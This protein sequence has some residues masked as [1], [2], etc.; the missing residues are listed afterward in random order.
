MATF[1]I[2]TFLKETRRRRVFRVIVLYI[3]GAWVALQ[4][5]DLVF[6]G[7]DIDESAIR[8]VW[9]GAILGFP[10][11]LLVGWRYDIVGGRVVRTAASA[12]DA[13]RALGRSDYTILAALAVVVAL[14]ALQMAAEISAT[15]VT[16]SPQFA[17]ADID[18]NSV[19]VLPFTNLSG[20]PDYEYLSDGLT[21]TLLHAVSQLPGLKVPARTSSF[22]FK[23]KDVD[24]REIAAQLSVAHV[25]EGSVQRAGNKF[26]VVAQLIE[27]DTGFHRWSK[28]YDREMS[29]IFAVQDD[30][31]NSVARAMHVTLSGDPGH[32]GGKIETVSTDNVVAY[33]MY[34]K[35]MQQKSKFSY[36]FLVLAELSFKEALALD[37]DFFEARL[38]LA[39]TY[40][41]QASTGEIA[42]A[43]AY[44]KMIFLVGQLLDQRPDNRL[45]LVLAIEIEIIRAATLEEGSLDVD[46]H[47]DQLSAAIES[48]P[49]ELRLYGAMID[50]LESA[51]RQEDAL[52]WA[53]RGIVIDPLSWRLHFRRG[54]GLNRSADLVG[55]EAAFKRAM[56]LNPDNPS[57]PA[58]AAN[59]SLQRKQY[60]QWFAM[61]RKAIDL[62]PLDP[63]IPGHVAAVLYEFGLTDEADKYLQRARAFAVEPAFSTGTLRR[64]LL[65]ND[66]VQARD[67]SEAML[68]DDINV[69]GNQYW[70]AAIVFISTMTELG[71]T[72]EA[73]AVLEELMP[74]VT[75][76]D[77]QPENFKQQML[78]Y[79]A[80]LGL[81]ESQSREETLRL[82]EAVVPRWDEAFPG[83]LQSRSMGTPIE[84]ARGNTELAIELA[85][86]DLSIFPDPF[87][88]RYL[89]FWKALAQEPAVAARLA[90]YDV[91][92]KR[93]GEEIWDYIVANNL[94]L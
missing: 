58:N 39:F 9:L 50:V 4:I 66:H 68:R 85:L 81:T 77:F 42:Q 61:N 31:A 49:N 84:M 76:P 43:E 55:A 69:H 27:A 45:A 80:V 89:Y 17:A 34:L 21:E 20:N 3:V 74:G 87:R 14:I 83:W 38:E 54:T 90:E 6:P 15:R 60:A 64:S 36:S 75:S 56:E 1:R 13:A 8:Y 57:I 46:K 59:V 47:F 51:N 37:P 19:A 7:L 29:D 72:D 24:I 22:F 5:A 16:E 65:R 67:R 71:E 25:L 44:E 48:T 2:T 73:L 33:E 10:V 91:E 30:I 70:W 53:E 28:T 78:H 41:D 92:T 18:P 12:G 11:A 52:A 86:V 88:Y 82:L 63:S 35:G 79:V 62:D 93:A 40:F 23:G 26:R 32:G 94:Q